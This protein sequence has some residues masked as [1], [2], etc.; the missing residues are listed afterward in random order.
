MSEVSSLVQKVR[1]RGLCFAAANI[2]SDAFQIVG[3]SLNPPNDY[4]KFLLENI[5]PSVARFVLEFECK[6]YLILRGNHR[7]VC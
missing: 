6:L 2:L 4:R 1:T 5:Q 7:N 3:H